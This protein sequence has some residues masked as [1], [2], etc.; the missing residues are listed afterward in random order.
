MNEQL[1]LRLLGEIMGWDD[2]KSR[3]EFAWLRLMARMKYDG[4]RDFQAGM[5]FI[6]SLACWL[7]QFQSSEER[8]T[9]YEFIRNELVYVGPAEMQ[10]LVKQFYPRFVRTTLT[11]LT[12]KECQIK[13]YRILISQ[14]AMSIFNRLN[15][16]VLYMGLSDGA[17]VDFVRRANIGQI[18]NEQIVIATQ[19]SDDKWQDLL[20]NLRRDLGDPTACFKMVYLIDDFMGTGTSFLRY[21]KEKTKWQGKL[22]KFLETQAKEAF[23]QDWH[24]CVHHYIGTHK[25][26]EVIKSRYEESTDYL[27]QKGWIMDPAQISFSFGTILPSEM[28]INETAS[29]DSFIELTKKYYDPAIETRHTLVGGTTHIGLGYGGCALPLILEHNTPNNSVALLWAETHGKDTSHAMRPLFRRR[30]R[31]S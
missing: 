10:T 15:R 6:E 2:S 9:A 30:Q 28:P 12:A 25:A 23:E 26:Q 18:N 3:S 5:R 27:I 21:S 20:D 19:V 22:I 7:Q 14:Q 31:H 11:Q 24:L 1:G 17:R 13:S 16:K 8:N 4:Y 29:L